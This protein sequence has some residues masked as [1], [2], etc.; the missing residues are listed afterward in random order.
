MNHHHTSSIIIHHHSFIIYHQHSPIWPCFGPCIF[1]AAC[2]PV[3]F[4]V[5]KHEAELRSLQHRGAPKL[6]KSLEV[7]RWSRC[8]CSPKKIAASLVFFLSV[9][10]A[11]VGGNDA[12][13]WAFFK[14]GLIW[15][16][17]NH[18]WFVSHFLWK[19]VSVCAKKNNGSAQSWLAIQSSGLNPLRQVS[20][21]GGSWWRDETQ[22]ARNQLVPS[23]GYPSQK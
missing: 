1:H 20:G 13:M 16:H 14:W 15:K 11:T 4:Q 10:Q 23:D 12:S 22:L 19:P 6:R 9:Q 17:T 18:L 5:G 3:T 7:V 21:I 2:L 8:F